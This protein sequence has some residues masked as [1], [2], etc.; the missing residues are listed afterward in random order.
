MK[1]VIFGIVVGL[2]VYGFTQTVD[3][4]TFIH[5]GDNDKKVNLTLKEVK[6]IVKTEPE[7]WFTVIT[8][9]D[10]KFDYSYSK[11]GTS[12]EKSFVCTDAS[13]KSSFKYLK[14]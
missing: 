5:H 11:K 1:C 12:K 4:E 10:C 8:V 14:D 3:A 9:K 6:E 7:T 13:A 2:L